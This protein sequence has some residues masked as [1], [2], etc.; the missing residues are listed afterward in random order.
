MLTYTKVDRDIL[1][2]FLSQNSAVIVDKDSCLAM[3][4]AGWH[5]KQHTPIRIKQNPASLMK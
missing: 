2:L 3:P 1:T 5:T 4:D